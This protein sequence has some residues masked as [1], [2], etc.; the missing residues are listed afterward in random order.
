MT[1]KVHTATFLVFE[2]LKSDAFLTTK[3][4]AKRLPQ[5]TTHQISAALH[6]MRK[7]KAVA[8]ETDAGEMY[9]FATPEEDNRSKTLEERTPEIKK[10]KPRRKAQTKEI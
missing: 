3:A 2:L 5:L 6:S 7:R 4:I 10:R 9:W 1:R 8:A